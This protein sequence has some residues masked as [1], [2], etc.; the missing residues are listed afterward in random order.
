LYVA[1]FKYKTT[2]AF[3]EDV[4]L[5]HSNSVLFNGPTHNITT[6]AKKLVGE[7]QSLLSVERRTLGADKDTFTV[8]ENDIRVK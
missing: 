3:I 5:I 2:T 1:K 6:A 4:E 8:Q 7:A